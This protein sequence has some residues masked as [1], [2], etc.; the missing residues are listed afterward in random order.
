MGGKEV[1]EIWE[2]VGEWVCSRGPLD[3]EVDSLGNRKPPEVL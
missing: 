2:P 3:L 1:I